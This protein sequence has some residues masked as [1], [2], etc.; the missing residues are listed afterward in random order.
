M[1]NLLA[2][3][4]LIR[5]NKALFKG[6]ILLIPFRMKNLNLKKKQRKQSQFKRNQY[7]SNIK[8]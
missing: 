1:G 2:G 7:R 3:N 5:I 4:Q 8:I 6:L